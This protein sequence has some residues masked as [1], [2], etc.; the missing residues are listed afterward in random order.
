MA[1]PPKQGKLFSFATGQPIDDPPEI[2]EALDI[3]SRIASRAMVHGSDPSA[4]V[5]P[6]H[7]LLLC[8]DAVVMLH[9]QYTQLQ[10]RWHALPFSDP[11]RD[12]LHEESKR[13]KAAIYKLL[14]RISKLQART[15]SGIFA[16]AGAVS[17]SG[18]SA[19][20]LGRWPVI[21]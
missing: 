18:Q 3:L 6:D 12:R 14:L 11:E 9:R 10:D 17:R 19:V 8:C 21:S 5:S 2:L 16:K 15:A 7:H 1:H 20:G 4:V 13:P